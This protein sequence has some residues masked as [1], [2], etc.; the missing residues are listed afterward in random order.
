MTEHID[1]DALRKLTGRSGDEELV[2]YTLL[3]S[4]ALDQAE[5]RIKAV[6]DV[7]DQEAPDPDIATRVRSDMIRRALEG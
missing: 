3:L 2:S 4:E 7:L 1:R 6:R 5:A